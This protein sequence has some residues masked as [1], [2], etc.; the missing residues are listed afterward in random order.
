[1]KTWKAYIMG[2]SIIDSTAHVRA[3]KGVEIPIEDVIRKSDAMK[4]IDELFLALNFYSGQVLV[5]PTVNRNMEGYIKVPDTINT[6]VK[7]NIKAVHAM[8]RAREFLDAG[9]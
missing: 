2:D 9:K 7:S 3:P 1:M 4:I 6:Y 5:Y 8:K